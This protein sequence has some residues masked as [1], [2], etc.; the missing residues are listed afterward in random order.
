VT[1][2]LKEAAVVGVPDAVEA[3]EDGPLEVE[4]LQAAVMRAPAARPTV[5]TSTRRTASPCSADETG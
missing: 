5:A 2:G 3:G 1:W 4:E